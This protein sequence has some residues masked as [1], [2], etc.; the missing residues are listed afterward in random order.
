MEEAE[1]TTKAAPV[2][3]GS[4][5][6]KRKRKT[7]VHNLSER[8]RSVAGNHEKLTN[9]LKSKKGKKNEI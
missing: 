3:R 8:V 5:G 4:K 2:P 7:E 9:I 6:A 1:G